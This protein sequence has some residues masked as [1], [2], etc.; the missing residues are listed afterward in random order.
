MS[1]LATAGSGSSGGTGTLLLFL[2]PLLLLGFL[3]FSQ[4]R[5]QR[6]VAQIQAE[7]AVGDEVMTSAGLF[8]RI[9]ALEERVVHLQIAP[10][11]VARWDRRA[12]LAPQAPQSTPPPG[13]G[14]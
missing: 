5:R 6:K 3:F 8:G 11:V 14:E 2:L 13:D 9:T 7:L 10:G 12:I 1:P 4:R